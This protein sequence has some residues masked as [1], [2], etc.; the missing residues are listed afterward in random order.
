MGETPK[1]GLPHRNALATLLPLRFVSLLKC[2]RFLI[3]LPLL[4]SATPT[5]QLGKITRNKLSWGYLAI[6][7]M[8]KERQIMG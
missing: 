5:N 6:A 4:T 2:D 7:V 1:T 8:I 3:L